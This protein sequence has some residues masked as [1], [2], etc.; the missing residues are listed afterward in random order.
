MLHSLLRKA[1]SK[2]LL[3]PQYNPRV[4]A[5]PLYS[6]N[7]F[8]KFFHSKVMLWSE[9]SCKESLLTVLQLRVR[10]RPD[11]V[12]AN[13]LPGIQQEHVILIPKGHVQA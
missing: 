7:I 11:S 4:I 9:F 13:S 3:G 10:F 12:A 8:S 6:L 2:Y 5:S 1:F